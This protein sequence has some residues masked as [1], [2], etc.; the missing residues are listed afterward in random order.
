MD[1]PATIVIDVRNLTKVFA[2]Q[3]AV[4]DV[5]FTVPSAC[6]F[7]FVGPSGSGKTTAIRLLLGLYPPT[8]GE[9]LVF[10]V[11]PTSFTRRDKQ[12]IGYMPQSSVLYPE[13]SVRQNLAFAGRVYGVGWGRRKRMRTL[14][15]LVELRE[16]QHKLARNVSGGM[17]RRLALASTLVH[18][19]DL[20]FLDEPTTGVDPVL[21]RKFWD[22]F[23]DLRHEGR[24]L[25]VTTQYVSEVENCDFV[26]L[27][28]DGGLLAVDTPTGLRRR[29]YGG[30]MVDMTPERPLERAELAGLRALPFTT[31]PIRYAG[32]NTIRL[33]VDDA[34][35]AMP[36][37][38][39]W[40]TAHGIKIDSI[41]QESPSFDD[42]FVELIRRHREAAPEAG[43]GDRG[44]PR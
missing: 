21:R 6:I 24:T 31:G 8:S 26:G 2:D 22:A 38:V 40:G 13:L 12:R 4:D 25:F 28:S 18:E 10:G 27:M 29:A 33:T 5:S 41:S 17:Q 9:V 34:T 44:G 3:R 11:P 15:E 36:Q 1:K 7:G 32:E 14:L 42:V 39:E 30:D 20:I 23:R 35:T 19:P 16:H 43:G 37:I